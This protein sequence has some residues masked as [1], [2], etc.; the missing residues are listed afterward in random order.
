MR[1]L[2]DSDVLISAKNS[3]YAFDI[4]PGFW[5]SLIDEFGRGNINSLDRIRQELMAGNDDDDLVTWVRDDVPPD[6][7][8]S[9][10]DADVVAAYQAIMLWA[11]RNP[12]F[13]DAAKAKF[14]TE[15][16]GWLVAHA[17]VHGL[18]VITNEQPRPDARN[19]IL[20]PDVCNQ[21]GVPVS[22]TFEMLRTLGMRF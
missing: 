20:L 11:Q 9:T 7:F 19:R 8:L 12:Q 16:D 22:N 14:A 6:F 10:R 1:Y 15:A 4:C 17:Q 13:V 2:V 3:Y 5:T 18:E 21:F